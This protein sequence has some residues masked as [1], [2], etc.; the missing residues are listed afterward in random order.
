MVEATVAHV[1][2]VELATDDG[3]SGAG[4][5]H[6]V[7]L[8]MLDRVTLNVLVSRFEGFDESRLRVGV[9]GV[10]VDLA[11][12][13]DGEAA[14]FLSPLISPHTVGNDG[15]AALAQEFLVAVGL[16]VEIGIFVIATLAAEVGQARGFDSG[17]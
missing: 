8:R 12:G 4:G 7:E 15:K 9:K 14:G 3:E 6:S 13:L 5:A 16:P 1:G 2:E 17:L 10:I 11:H